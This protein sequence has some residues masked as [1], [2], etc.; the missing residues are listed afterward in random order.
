V[1]KEKEAKMLAD[2]EK[3]MQRLEEIKECKEEWAQ[4]QFDLR[5]ACQRENPHLIIPDNML[6]EERYRFSQLTQDP[7]KKGHM[8]WIPDKL[9]FYI[10]GTVYDPERFAL[11][12]DG[13]QD[14]QLDVYRICKRRHCVNP[15]HLSL[16]WVD[17]GG[18]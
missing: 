3:L 12:L 2:Y 14:H 1:N 15:K 4:K 18:I 8:V 7:D 5:Q 16:G 9:E 11:A 17:T 10:R 13:Q 6:S